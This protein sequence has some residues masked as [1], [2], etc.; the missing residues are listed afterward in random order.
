MPFIVLDYVHRIFGE[1]FGNVVGCVA[2]GCLRSCENSM[3]F[4]LSLHGKDERSQQQ[5]T[6]ESCLSCRKC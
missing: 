6:G 2:E 1:G 5:P 4:A 3:V